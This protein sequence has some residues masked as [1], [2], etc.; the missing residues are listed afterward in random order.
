M[1]K[2][3]LTE[4]IR[5]VVRTEMAEQLP[6]LIVEI[7]STKSKPLPTKVVEQR[8]TIPAQPVVKPHGLIVR[9]PKLQAVL[10]ETRGGV[11]L[12]TMAPIGAAVIPKELLAEN[13][14]LAAVDTA[15]KKDYRG[16]LKAMDKNK[17]RGTVNFQMSPPTSFE[18][19]PN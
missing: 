19:E 17:G 6:S 3:E 7:L 15:M 9:D 10:N 14:E 2:A 12:E 11:P 4:I 5:N 8:R 18:Q 16:F 13:K 1:T